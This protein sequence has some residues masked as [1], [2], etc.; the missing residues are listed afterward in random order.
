MQPR[1]IYF[2][3]QIPREA[4]QVMHLNEHG[5]ATESHYFETMHLEYCPACKAGVWISRLGTA[6]WWDD[7]EAYTRVITGW[8]DDNEH[9]KLWLTVL[10][11]FARGDTRIQEFL[12]EPSAKVHTAPV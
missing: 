11:A 2:H 7:H 5:G 12:H 8:F 10:M 9:D 1:R 3:L 6:Q 4:L